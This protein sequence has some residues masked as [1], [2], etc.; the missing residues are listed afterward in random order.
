M[1]TPREQA[2]NAYKA[3]RGMPRP[4]HVLGIDDDGLAELR[5][6]RLAALTRAVRL[7]K[8]ATGTPRILPGEWTDESL[9]AAAAV[10]EADLAAEAA[11]PLPT[12]G[13]RPGSANTVITPDTTSRPP[14]MGVGPPI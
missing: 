6:G 5:A 1:L 12:A 4:G 9:S 14:L 10:V 13:S 11:A 2:S 3:T 7:L 8:A